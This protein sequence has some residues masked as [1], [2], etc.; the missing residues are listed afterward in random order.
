MDTKLNLT[1]ALLNQNHER[2]SWTKKGMKKDPGG[3]YYKRGMVLAI[4]EDK[5]ETEM[6]LNRYIYAY[7]PEI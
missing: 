4:L 6:K 7:G 5:I 3:E 2:Y 1:E